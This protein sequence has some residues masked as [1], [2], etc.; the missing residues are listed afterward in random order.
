MKIKNK[1]FTIAALFLVFGLITDS[2]AQVRR[3]YNALL[4]GTTTMGT[5]T[6]DVLTL[7]GPLTSNQSYSAAQTVFYLRSS[8]T[9]TSGTHNNLRARAQNQA[10]SASTSDIR[11]VYA[12][13][14]TSAGLFGGSSTAIYA[15]AIAKGTSTT[16]NLRGILIDTES[17]GTPTLITNMW[18]LYIRNKSTVAITTDNY[19]I[20]IDNEKMGSGIVQDAGIQLKTTTWGSGVTAW[21]YGIDMNQTGAFGTADIRFSNG[22]TLSNTS[23]GVLNASGAD[24]RAASYNFADATAVAGTGDATTID[25]TPNLAALGAGLLVMYVA[26]AANTGAMTLAIDGGDA[27]AVNESSDNS[28]L[29]ANDIRSGSVVLLLYDGT[30]WQQLS[31]SGN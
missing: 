1:L 21:T 19:S 5:G 17:E 4:R 13:A 6:G 8:L 16:T 22:E 11:G 2:S 12:Q 28:A 10:T 7:N 24:F 29:E 20:T 26:E 25:F 14:T 18:G 30:Q 9:A 15:N 3:I 27:K 23:D 31:Q